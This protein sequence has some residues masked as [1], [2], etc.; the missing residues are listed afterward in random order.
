MIVDDCYSQPEKTSEHLVMLSNPGSAYLKIM[1]YYQEEKKWNSLNTNSTENWEKFL[2]QYFAENAEM[3]IKI[4]NNEKLNYEISKF[5]ILILDTNSDNMP[6]VYCH[7]NKSFLNKWLFIDNYQESFENDPDTGT[8]YK[9]ISIKNSLNVLE[10]KNTK[11]FLY[12]D[13]F[14]KFNLEYKFQT[15]NVAFVN[16][17]IY[18]E[19]NSEKLNVVELKNKF[20]SLYS[21]F[22]NFMNVNLLFLII[23]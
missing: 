20:F 11:V 17:E 3:T 19:T 9:T 8:L 4:Y 1:Q 21:K 22:T 2:S 12:F 10:Y 7:K 18:D 15:V 14:C 23:V 6:Y 5:D 16:I 13:A